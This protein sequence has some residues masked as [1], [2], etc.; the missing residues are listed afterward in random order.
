MFGAC[1]QPFY[2]PRSSHFLFSLLP[3]PYIC[4]KTN[5]NMCIKGYPHTWLVTLMM[6]MY[7]TNYS[8]KTSI[9]STSS[10]YVHSAY[11]SKLG[12]QPNAFYFAKIRA[13]LPKS[14]YYAWKHYLRICSPPNWDNRVASSH[15]SDH[16]NL[17]HL[18]ICCY[19]NYMGSPCHPVQTVA[20]DDFSVFN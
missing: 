6:L 17:C 5:T 7:C 19:Y 15:P 2:S 1:S 4:E 12:P 11:H 18:A 14:W 8:Y 3:F 13:M 10:K 20:Q 9:A 16:I